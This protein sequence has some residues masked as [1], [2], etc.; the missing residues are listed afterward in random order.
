MFGRRELIV[1]YSVEQEARV[2]YLLQSHG[3]SSTSE[4]L[5]QGSSFSPE[6]YTTPRIGERHVCIFYVKKKDYNHAVGVLHE[7]K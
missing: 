7:G 6:R 5:N 4:Y 1:V 3:I 2:R